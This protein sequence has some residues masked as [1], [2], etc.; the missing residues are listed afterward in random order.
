MHPLAPVLIILGIILLEIFGFAWVG[1]QV[2]GLWTV[3]L[4][5]LTA[6]AGFWIFRIQGLAHAR[7][8]QAALDE[9]ELPARD[10]IEGILLLVAAILLLLP[11]FFSDLV[12]FLLLLPPLRAMAAARIAQSRTV[13]VAARR[14]AAQR[15]ARTPIEGEFQRSDSSHDTDHLP[16]DRRE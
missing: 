16:P 3:I 1:S 4:V 9:G 13:W 7:R 10:L 5:I 6:A 15:R 8:M 14:H 11:G 2:G 12:G